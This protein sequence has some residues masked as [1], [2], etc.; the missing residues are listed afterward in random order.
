MLF[1]DLGIQFLVYLNKLKLIVYGIA[2]STVF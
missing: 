1:D 2:V